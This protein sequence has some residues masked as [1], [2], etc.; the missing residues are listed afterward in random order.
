MRVA[1]LSDIHGNSIALDA[2][3]R[4]VEAHGG[5]DAYWLLGDLAAIGHDPLGVLERVARLP[6][7]ELVRGNTDR[8]LVTGQRPGPT[9]AACEADPG[10]WPVRVEVA[11]SFSWTQ[12]VVTVSGWID[13]LA[14]LPLERRFVL[15][16][17]TRVLCVH[18]SPGRD[19]GPGVHPGLDREALRPLLAGCDADLVFVGHTHWPLDV[20]VDGVRLVNAGSV[21]NAFPPDLRAGYVLLEAEGAG[22]RLE[23]RRVAYDREAVVAA[24]HEVNHPAA[25]Y[26]GRHM[27]GQNR[28]HWR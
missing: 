16:D 20:E 10:L 21:S 4:D 9:A 26:I 18:A 28:P 5:V 6:A 19:D 2:V 25:A 24:L 14:E 1:I 8:Y 27:R 11:G 13:W 17:G 3:L 12:G 22:Y 7:V 23:Q 15:P